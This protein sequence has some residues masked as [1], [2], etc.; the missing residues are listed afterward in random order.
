MDNICN[1]VIAETL[2]GVFVNN[3]AFLPAANTCGGILIAASSDHYK[4]TAQPQLL[5]SYSLSVLITDLSCNLSWMLTGVYGPQLDDDKLAFLSEMRNR[6]PLCT[7]EWLIMGD[8]NL[9]SHASDKSNQNLNLR[10][11]RSFRAAIDDLQ[12]KDFPL[13]GRRFT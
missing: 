10:M 4:L 2:G 9:I 11:I 7:P 6:K 3:F 12:L 1:S 8:F 13:I 5:G